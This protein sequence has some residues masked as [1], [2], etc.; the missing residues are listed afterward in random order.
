MIN[1]VSVMYDLQVI[2]ASTKPF[3]GHTRAVYF[4]CVCCR[5]AASCREAA[6]TGK[7]SSGAQT[8]SLKEP[9]RL[10][11]HYRKGTS[12]RQAPV[13]RHLGAL[14]KSPWKFII[15]MNEL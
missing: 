6:R 8:T 7:S 2:L 9:H 13:F 5:M 14:R 3:L 11:S 10:E 4:R 15:W 1:E 12:I